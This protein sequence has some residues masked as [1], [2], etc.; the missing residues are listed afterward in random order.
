MPRLGWLLAAW[1]M[2]P[3]VLDSLQNLAQS[4]HDE[5]L[6][7]H[8]E[9]VKKACDAEA[10][11]SAAAQDQLAESAEVLGAEDAET[12]ARVEELDQQ[13]VAK[14]L[15]IE[16]VN[17]EI[18]EQEKARDAARAA[19]EDEAKTLLA[20][21]AELGD[22]LAKHA[23]EQYAD[24]TSLSQLRKLS[25]SLTQATRVSFLQLTVRSPELE[26]EQAEINKQIDAGRKAFDAKLADYNAK[27]K[28]LHEQLAAHEL[29]LSKLVPAKANAQSRSSG[30]G[31]RKIDVERTLGHVKATGEASNAF[32]QH[33]LAELQAS[34][35]KRAGVEHDLA[36]A[37]EGLSSS[38]FTSLVEKSAQ[39]LDMQAA[40]PSFVQL[41]TRVLRTEM[42]TAMDLS[43]LVAT[44]ATG[45]LTKTAKVLSFAPERVEAEV[46]EAASFGERKLRAAVAKQ[47]PRL[48]VAAPSFVQQSLAVRTGVEADPFL[49]VKQKIRMLIDSLRDSGNKDV[50]LVDWCRNEE[51]A[52]ARNIVKREQDN[53][54]ALATINENTEREG[55]L[56]EQRGLV[57]QAELDAGTAAAAQAQ[58]YQEHEFKL[59]EQKKAHELAA[60]VLADAARLVQEFY[61]VAEGSGAFL[62][63]T[64]SEAG[65]KEAAERAL[66]QLQAAEQQ[67]KELIHAQET[68]KPQ[69]QDL[70]KALDKQEADLVKARKQELNSIEVLV[71]GLADQRLEAEQQRETGARE[72]EMMKAEKDQV[73][74]E[75]AS[76]DTGEDAAE[77]RQD[78]IA[79]LQDA[80]KVLEGEDI[81]IA[82]LL[83]GGRGSSD[84]AA[85]ALDRAAA[86]LGI[87]VRPQ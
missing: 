40:P 42:F 33:M 57:Q 81:P 21:R 47:A 53:D 19:Y 66:G 5:S 44:A 17:G 50:D 78:E 3:K 48:G 15:E 12:Q 64:P 74:Q 9:A 24:K 45:L 55:E 37:I 71:N 25:R 52:N 63:Q 86:A 38:V 34:E 4:L 85:Q 26:Q 56:A 18:A 8:F 36:G 30:A 2:P 80:V 70:K 69:L 51:E 41:Q 67:V 31:A 11:R 58:L 14:K 76:P 1:A 65:Q 87:R 43:G 68:S 6:S 32:C 82:G 22:A 7:T 29:D 75:C 13:V 72:V 10:A 39:A 46:Q 83:Q 77:R 79:A 23:E 84:R 60:E 20:S 28:E 35:E 59:D 54:M 49:A 73:A 16:Q 62:Q 61:G 27:L